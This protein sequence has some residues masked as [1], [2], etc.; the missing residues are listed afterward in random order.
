MAK[1]LKRPM[2]YNPELGDRICELIAES[3]IGI[4]KIIAENDWMPSVATLFMWI[5]IYDDFEKQYA[6]A[7]EMQ[8]ETLAEQILEIS[9]DSSGDNL[10]TEGG[11]IENREFVNRSRLR[12]DSRKW[13][14]SKL[15]PKKYGDRTAIEHSGELRTPEPPPI[16]FNISPEVAK[17]VMEAR[18]AE[19]K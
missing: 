12:V 1:R 4:K 8:A 3:E 17:E 19:P 9:D 15:L 13:L 10:I 16:I 18:D 11:V 7:K 14:A 5:R 2:D 6:R